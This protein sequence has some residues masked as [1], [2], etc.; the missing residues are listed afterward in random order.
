MSHKHRIKKLEAETGVI[1]LEQVRQE[2]ARMTDEER[3]NYVAELPNNTLLS[4]VADGLGITTDQ[5]TSEILE[6]VARGDYNP[7]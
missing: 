7:A 6:A 3:A 4:I 5:V 1:P 2:A